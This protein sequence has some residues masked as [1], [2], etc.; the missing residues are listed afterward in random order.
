[1]VTNSWM[2]IAGGACLQQ[3]VALGPCQFTED[4]GI[5]KWKRLPV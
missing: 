3:I 5:P 2:E 1:M 4:S